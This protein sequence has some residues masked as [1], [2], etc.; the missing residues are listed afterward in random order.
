MGIITFL[1][2][3]HKKQ[4]LKKLDSLKKLSTKYLES[5]E[6]YAKLIQADCSVPYIATCNFNSCSFY[7]VMYNSYYSNLADIFFNNYIHFERMYRNTEK[8]IKRIE[9][10]LEVI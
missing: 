1:K 8:K 5:S 4:L 3:R 9:K 10:K 6:T 7:S 2:K